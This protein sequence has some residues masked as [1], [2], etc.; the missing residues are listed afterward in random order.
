[1]EE[2]LSRH[3]GQDVA[4]L[5]EDTDRDLILSA[6]DAVAYGIADAVIDSRK[7]GITRRDTPGR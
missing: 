6:P 4:R 2:I 3:T 1:M 7:N 5:R